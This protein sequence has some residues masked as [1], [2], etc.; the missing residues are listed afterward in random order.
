MSLFLD[1]ADVKE[2]K[3]LCEMLPIDGVTTNPSIVAKENKD[4]L[5]LINEIKMIIGK[6]KILHVQALG[7]TADEIIEEAEYL[8]QKIQENLFIKIPVTMEG[9]KAI[10][11]LKQ[12]GIKTTATAVFTTQQAVIAAK[13]G[14]EYVAPYINRLANISGSGIQVISEIIQIYKLL[15]IDT[16]VIAAS[17]KNIEQINKSFLAGAHAVTVN[18]SLIRQMISHP[19]T[20][21]SVEGFLKDWEG[22]YGTNKLTNNL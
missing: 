18:P 21:W 3:I 2:I 12:K 22:T 8:N 5:K 16:K 9:I 11:N 19:L 6:D 20:D 14:A 1:T 7:K 4:F 13:A 17:F 15:G 10:K